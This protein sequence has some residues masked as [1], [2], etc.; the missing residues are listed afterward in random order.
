LELLLLDLLQQ[1]QLPQTII[2]VDGD[3]SS[4]QV[5]GLLRHLDFPHDVS[6]HFI[7][8]NYSNLSYQRYVGWLVASLR[9]ALFLLYLD[10]DLRIYERDVINKLMGHIQSD[11]DIAGC[12]AVIRMGTLDEKFSNNSALKEQS[13]SENRIVAYAKSLSPFRNTLPGGLTPVGH[14]ISPDHSGKTSA[15]E[16]LHGGV[17]LFRMQSLIKSSFSADLFALDHIRCG[18]GED[19]FLSRQ[20]MRSGKLIYANDVIIDH[21]NSDLPAAYPISAY[22]L[23]YATAYSR[24]FQNDHY[25]IVRPPY[26]TDRL[27]LFKSYV[28]NNLINFVNALHN[29]RRYRF[30]YAFGYL[31]GS[32]RGLIQ[33]PTVNNLTPHINWWTKAEEAVSQMV[34]V[35]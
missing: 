13:N 26:F 8:S 27:H 14:R 17:M 35:Q 24:R 33:S 5:Q 20:V 1:T 18:K 3:P 16:W 25:R 21:P 2:I 30:T 19:T 32:F 22:K 31:L 4:G 7:P 9:Q 6:I 28:G 29:P 15:V 34:T 10:D 12:T 11:S 23:A